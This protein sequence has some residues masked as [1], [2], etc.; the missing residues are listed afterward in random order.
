MIYPAALE[1]TVRM[2]ANVSA[3]S[4]AGR[5]EASRARCGFSTNNLQV[6]IDFKNGEKR[7]V[8]FAQGPG[9]RLVYG[10]VVLAGEPWVF[11]FPSSL[12]AYVQTYLTIPDAYR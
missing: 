7:T 10:C 11:E 12:Y 1:E 4:W 9:T 8:E 6:A 2:L 3:V 5:G